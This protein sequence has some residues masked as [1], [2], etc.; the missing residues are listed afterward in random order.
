M[1]ATFIIGLREGLEAALIVGIIAAFLRKNGKSLFAMWV[2]VVLALVLSVIVGIALE[3][4]ERALPQASQEGMES[5]IGAVAVF[6]VTGMIMWMNTHAHNMKK[7]LESDAAEAISQSSA[8]ALASMAFLA[9][10]KEGFETSVFLLATFSVAQSA[11][12]AA[13]GAV[14]GLIVAVIIGC[15]LYFGGIRINLSRFFRFTGLFLILVAGGLIITSLQTAHEAGWLNIGQQRIADLSWLVPPGTVRS[16]LIT[17]VLGI[18][19][20]PNQ[21]QT[22]AWLLYI[23]MVSVMVYWPAHRRPAPEKAA[24]LS[25]VFAG[26]MALAALSLW[27]FYPPFT[28]QLPDSA[29]LVSNAQTP[30]GQVQLL[31]TADNGYQLSV[32]SAAGKITQIPLARDAAM[33]GERAGLPTREWNTKTSLTPAGAPDV[34]SLDQVV[35]L[36]GNRIPIGLNPAMHPGPYQAQWT[37]HCNVQVVAAGDALLDASGQADEVITLSGSGLQ[38]PRTVTVRTPTADV[39]ACNWQLSYAWQQHVSEALQQRQRYQD[40]YRFWAYM[41]PALLAA[42]ALIFAVSALRVLLK[43]RHERSSV[44]R[45]YDLSF[46]SQ[47]HTHL[48]KNKG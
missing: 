17:G 3:M 14:T 47:P 33:S 15:G 18:P 21:I 28:L 13:V 40:T 16:A 41:L 39:S 36:Y 6:F 43:F 4:T 9:V 24:G 38:S 12:W 27:L 5:V 48:P 34:V 32:Q 30:A 20:D 1:L 29:P 23:G 7:E 8:W 31:V 10:L 19:A 2:G 22:V 11:M 46:G 42:L 45:E 26:V 37:V 25:M 35:A 44:S